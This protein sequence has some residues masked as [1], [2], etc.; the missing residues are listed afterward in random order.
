M[1]DN[2]IVFGQNSIKFDTDKKIYIDPFQ[3]KDNYND[4]DII[5]ITHDHYDHFSPNDIEKVIK[6]NTVIV[7]P[8][9]MNNLVSN[10]K[11]VLSVD[12]N[13]SYEVLGV[14]FSTVPSYNIEKKFHPK[15]KKYVGYILNIDNYK[16]YIAGDTD[17]ISDI[18]NISCDVA[19]LP[20]GGT[21]TMDYN[22][23]FELVASMRPK[24]VVPVHYGS[25]VGNIEDGIKFQ[26]LVENIGI[27]CHV[28]IK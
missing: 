18:K 20:I 4:A 3:I 19:F 22:E 27:E 6:D 8:K 10:Y 11:N 28:F 24:I 25:I 9:C 23:A 16:Y 21:F 5:F 2:V 14:K 7:V 13:N 12:I 17:N 26:H 15:D 1:L